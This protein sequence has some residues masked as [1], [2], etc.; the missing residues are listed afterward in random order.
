MRDT[1]GQPTERCHVRQC[2]H[3][4]FTERAA[5]RQATAFFRCLRH[6]EL[7]AADDTH[8]RVGGIGSHDVTER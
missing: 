5:A 8:P 2:G 3:R 6:P 4:W 1:E 7:R